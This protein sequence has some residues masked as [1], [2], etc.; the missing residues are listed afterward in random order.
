MNPSTYWLLVVYLLS[1][2]ILLV[3]TLFELLSKY[4]KQRETSM[5]MFLSMIWY[6]PIPI[7]NAIVLFI[8]ICNLLAALMQYIT[9]SEKIEKI[10]EKRLF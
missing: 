8:L 1:I 4:K 9:N 5:S 3:N 2:F 7:I 6:I 10:L